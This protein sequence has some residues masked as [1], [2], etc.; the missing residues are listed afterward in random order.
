MKTS[1]GIIEHQR[2]SVGEAC[3]G[4]C[5]D[6]DGPLGVDLQLIV[7]RLHTVIVGKTFLGMHVIV[8]QKVGRGLRAR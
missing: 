2:D 3:R 6:V 1:V 5:P 7:R 8:L 4:V